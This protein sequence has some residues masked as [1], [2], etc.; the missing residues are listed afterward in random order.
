[1]IALGLRSSLRVTPIL[2]LDLIRRRVRK[3]PDSPIELQMP[4]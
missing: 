4:C 2:R 3:G 1:M